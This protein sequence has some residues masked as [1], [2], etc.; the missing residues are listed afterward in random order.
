MRAREF[1][2]NVPI[3]I[4]INGDADPE[5]ETG[6]KEQEPDL[7]QNPVMIPP[8]QQEL[9]LRKAELG[10]ETP[11]IDKLIADHDVGEEPHD[12]SSNLLTRL[13]ELIQK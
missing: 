7:Q 3:K 6:D 11:V 2:I 4:T 8:L 5:I 13:K 1:T 12:N 10:K 9:E